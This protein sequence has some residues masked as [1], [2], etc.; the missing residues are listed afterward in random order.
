MNKIIRC[1]W[2]EKTEEERSYHDNEWGRPLH[3]ERKLFEMLILE[4][5]QAGLSWSIILKKR[6]NFRKAYDNFDPE[7]IAHYNS[8]K[9][10]E[11]LMNSGIIRN[12]LKINAAITNAKAYL[13]LKESNGSL[14]SY[15]WEFVDTKPIISHWNEAAQLPVKNQ[16]SDSITKDLKKRGFKFI[17]STTIYSYLQAVGIIDDHLL[18]CFI[19]SNH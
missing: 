17:G 6:E 16:L 2:A 7:K 9:I 12:K 8:K 3:D 19:R 15:L 4:G 10:D 13:K 18:T 1:P 14:D 11:L 5:Q